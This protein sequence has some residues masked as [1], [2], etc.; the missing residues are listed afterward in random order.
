MSGVYLCYVE[1]D[2]K[3]LLLCPIEYLVY[4]GPLHVMCWLILR[5]ALQ[6]R[7]DIIPIL[8]V[9]KPRFRGVF[10]NLTMDSVNE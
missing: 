7:M 9:R 4:T 5:A 8:Q 6:G 1:L 3:L 2:C 10:S